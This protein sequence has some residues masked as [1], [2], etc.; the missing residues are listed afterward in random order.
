MTCIVPTYIL[1]SKHE[2]A[3]ANQVADLQQYFPNAEIIESIFPNHEKVPFLE[4]LIKKSKER[5]GQALLMNEIGVLLS[6]RK[7]WQ[8]IVLKNKIKNS[9]PNAHYLILESDSK[10]NN[11]E[12]IQTKLDIVTKN[13]D[14]FY[15]G[16]WNNH[17][18]IK[19]S[20][21][22]NNH[23]KYKMGIPLIKSVYGA[24]GYS[25]NIKAAHQML[26]S[27]CKIKYPVDLYKHYDLITGLS[28]GAIQPELIST[29]QTTQSS[30][31][32]ETNW[33]KFKR[34][35]RIKIFSCRNQIQAYFC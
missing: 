26:K 7:V 15:W 30:I 21:I 10:I 29:W 22:L 4:K 8:T 24:Y 25:I 31:R 1:Y 2:V 6:H 17:V 23:E 28:I 27:T 35:L 20:S 32:P 11:I 16:A 3:R 13:Y 33:D 14:L 9:N 12:L 19:K 5:T 34:I 18:S